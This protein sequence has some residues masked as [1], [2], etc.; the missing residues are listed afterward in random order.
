MMMATLR[1]IA[2]IGLLSGLFLFSNAQGFNDPSKKESKPYRIFTS[3]KQI[4]VKSSKDIK[5]V[6][7]WTASGHRII[8]Q[9]EINSPSY[10]FI[11][12]VNE[13]IFFVMLEFANDQ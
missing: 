5:S 13:K 9:R 8:E 6:M 2:T 7:V 1:K 10:T 3:G 11:V 12:G 4:T